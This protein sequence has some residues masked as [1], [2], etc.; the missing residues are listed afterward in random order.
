[1]ESAFDYNYPLPYIRKKQVRLLLYFKLYLQI[2]L[3]KIAFE[4]KRNN[5][6]QLVNYLINK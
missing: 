4:T 1:M 5:K 6:N 3:I 2:N